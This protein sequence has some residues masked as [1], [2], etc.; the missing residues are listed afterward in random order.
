MSTTTPMTMARL[1]TDAAGRYGDRPAL[2]SKHGGEWTDTSFTQVAQNVEQLALGLIALG[3]Q[4][5]DRVCVL[6][7]TQPD[8]SI[9]SL[10]I[11]SAGAV[12]VTIYPSSSAEEREWVAGNTSGYHR[13]AQGLRADAR[14]LRGGGQRGAAGPVRPG[15][16]ARRRDPAAPAAR[17]AGQ[18]EAAGG[19][20]AIS[21]PTAS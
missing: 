6:A 17:R 12:L 19:I 3:I 2:R 10:A 13:P 1:T 21:A 14:R 4:P 16:R 5:G 11:W 8:W 7:D 15:G 18:R 9:A 20:R